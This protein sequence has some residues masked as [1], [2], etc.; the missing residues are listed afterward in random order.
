MQI[1][2][3]AGWWRWA[4]RIIG[5]VLMKD[6]CGKYLIWKLLKVF[7]KTTT[8]SHFASCNGGELVKISNM[9]TYVWFLCC[10]LGFPSMIF[11][12]VSEELCFGVLSLWSEQYLCHWCSQVASKIQLLLGPRFFSCKQMYCLVVVYM[13][14]SFT[15][16]DST[17]CTAI[18]HNA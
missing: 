6:P 3:E 16:Y 12:K 8:Y 11:A 17:N 4:W 18:V 14:I 5:C 13:Y 2:A 9:H 15:S 10:G 1:F 7:D